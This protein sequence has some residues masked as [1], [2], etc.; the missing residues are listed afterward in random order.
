MCHCTCMF[1]PRRKY[2]TQPWDT[3]PLLINPLGHL[4]S[5]SSLKTETYWFGGAALHCFEWEVP[6]TAQIFDHCQTCVGWDCDKHTLSRSTK[7]CLFK[8]TDDIELFYPHR[9][10]AVCLRLN[11]SPEP[12]AA[13]W[14]VSFMR[15]RL[16]WSFYL[17][18]CLGR[19]QS[20]RTD[21]Q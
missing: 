7:S 19:Q 4:S 1:I 11:G 6:H 12:G 13:C 10:E 2:S 17:S 14:R 21:R 16:C 5:F 15:Q 9:Q 8:L 3:R 20:R 18:R